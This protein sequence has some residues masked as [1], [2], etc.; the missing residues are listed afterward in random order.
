MPTVDANYHEVSQRPPGGSV[1]DGLAKQL[2]DGVEI[3]DELEA[4]IDQ[5][6]ETLAGLWQKY[7]GYDPPGGYYVRAWISASDFDLLRVRNAIAFAAIGAEDGDWDYEV[8]EAMV[9]EY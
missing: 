6:T 5:A 9:L 1:S 4:A 7:T 2:Q 8:G 3:I